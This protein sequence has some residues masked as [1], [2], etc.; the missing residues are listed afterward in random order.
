MAITLTE[1]VSSHLP[2]YWETVLDVPPRAPEKW[3]T[4]SAIWFLG[5]QY[6]VSPSLDSLPALGEQETISYGLEARLFDPTKINYVP[7]TELGKR[8][9][10][11]REQAMRAGMKLL[12]VDEVL[13]EVR[14]RRGE[15]EEDEETH[16]P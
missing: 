15:L 9:L 6:R 2:P 3:P 7:R 14:R 10:L 5:S 12:S 1:R 11:L 4:P 13:E 8:L 16:L